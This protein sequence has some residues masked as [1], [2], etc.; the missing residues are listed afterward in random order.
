MIM[1]KSGV[2]V[3][4]KVISVVM[5]ISGALGV[6]NTLTFSWVYA[7]SAVLA[8]AVA[9]GLWMAAN[10]PSPSPR[11]IRTIIGLA[12]LRVLAT[13]AATIAIAGTET[14]AMISGFVFPALLLAYT[15]MQLRE[16]SS[17][18]AAQA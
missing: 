1:K 15:V 8:I 6:V 17:E 7:F 5:S 16:L 11:L 18:T 14:S 12:G 10:A 9:Y 13:V 3:R 4:L 2:R